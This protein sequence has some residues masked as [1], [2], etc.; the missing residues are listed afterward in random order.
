MNLISQI[1]VLTRFLWI[2]CLQ[3]SELKSHSYSYILHCL[4]LMFDDYQE[5]D[6]TTTRLLLS[7]YI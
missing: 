6:F 7:V 4:V 3:T 2:P 5:V 1:L